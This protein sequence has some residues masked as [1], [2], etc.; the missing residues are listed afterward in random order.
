MPWKTLSREMKEKSMKIISIAICVS[1]ALCNRELHAADRPERLEFSTMNADWAEYGRPDYIDF[2]AEAK[3][4]LVQFGFYGAHFWGLA[5]TPY[6][7]GYPAH[8]PVQGH[9]ACGE[10][11]AKMTRAIK[12][13]GAKVVGH[14][15]VKFLVGDPESKD[16]PRGFFKFYRDQWDPAVLGPKPVEDIMSMLEIDDHGKPIINN[17]Y[18]IGGMHEYWACLNNPDWRKV[19]K[20]WTKYGIDRGVDGFIANY[21]YRHDCHCKYCVAGFKTYL[22]G[23]YSPEEL[24]KQ[25]GID[26]LASHHFA[27]IVAWHDPKESTPLR[28]EMLRW[29]QIANKNAFDDVFVTYGRSLKPDLIVAQWDHLGAFN[30]ISGDERCMLPAPLWGKGEDYL[31]YSLGDTG[32]YTDLKSVYL[33]E[34]TL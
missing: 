33:G 1:L 15:N 14:M 12:S 21:F 18:N 31:W 7:K 3:P 16:G 23:R 8:F 29:S 25:F 28:R 2:I 24:K 19:L 13:H 20:A 11:F 4:D 22:S 27:E 10:W 32:H 6:G 26:D 17:S 34:G 30:E 5:D 9:Q